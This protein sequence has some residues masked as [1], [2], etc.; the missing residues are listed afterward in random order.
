MA[1]NCNNGEIDPGVFELLVAGL[2]NI[3]LARAVLDSPTEL[4]DHNEAAKLLEQ[5]VRTNIK[6]VGA[7]PYAA[8]VEEAAL[9][10]SRQY[11]GVME[12][13]LPSSGRRRTP[14]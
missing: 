4:I 1:V 3:A 7:D 13:V 2:V 5:L 6:A 8:I 10:F 9:R 14:V 11:Y 12:N